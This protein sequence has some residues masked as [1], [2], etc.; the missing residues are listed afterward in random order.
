[1]DLTDPSCFY[2]GNRKRDTMKLSMFGSNMKRF[3]LIL[4]CA[5]IRQGS[6]V[7]LYA[8]S[9]TVAAQYLL[10]ALNQER[11]SHRLALVRLDA[12]LNQAAAIH[13]A[14]MAKNRS[15]SHQFPGE[16]ELSVRGSVSGA[17]FDRI[18]ENVA[19]GPAATI[20]HDAW[21]H[22]PGHRANILDPAVDAVGIAVVSRNGQLYAVQDFE[23]SVQ[24]LSFMQQEAT[25][26][27]L[28]DQS[29]LELLPG[30]N[31]RQTCSMATG[32][33]GEQQPA[34]VVRYTTG[35]ISQL[36][37]RLK[38]RLISTQDRLAAV[39]A[40]PTDE[41]S[42]FSTYSLVVLLYK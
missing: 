28:L 14:V 38:T 25:V 13:A 17:R 32:Y 5:C 1:M 12:S 18:T 9:Q 35:D 21:M 31:A 3:A 30:A 15:I 7:D 39:G 37:S 34:F 42:A 8:Q 2:G 6:G 4:F 27:L 20:I 16:A 11:I 23:R 29:G 33:A 26:G 10:S 19:E 24:S 36:P 22:S 40:C 41:T